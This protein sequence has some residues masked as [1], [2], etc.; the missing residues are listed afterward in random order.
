M[1]KTLPWAAGDAARPLSATLLH[2]VAAVLYA[3]G[4]MLTRHATR[5]TTAK[6]VRHSLPHTVE[7]HSFHR[8]AG[9]PEGAL[10]VNGQLVGVI[11]GVTR[12]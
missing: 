3:A 11:E 5:V 8:E 12:L 7:F 10:Y 9:A 1:I 4:E 2:L 6:A